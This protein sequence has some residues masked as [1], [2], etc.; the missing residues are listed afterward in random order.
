MLGTILTAI[1]LFAVLLLVTVSLIL[2]K[3]K[4]R[5]SCSC[6]CTC[7][8]CPSAELCHPQKR[9]DPKETK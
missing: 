1:A 3:R 4:G 7:S 2:N 9:E 8:S 5:S 6:G